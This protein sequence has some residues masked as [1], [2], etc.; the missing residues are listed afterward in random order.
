M[1]TVFP[2]LQDVAMDFAWGGLIDMTKNHLPDFGRLRS[3]IYYAQ[4]FSGHGVSMT[5]L[6]GKLMAEVIAGTAE[7]FDVF[8]RIP[9]RSIPLNPWVRK[10]LL[11]LA[12][13]WYGLQDKLP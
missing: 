5:G 6:A 8:T 1:L 3:N 13:L 7:R 9:H 12:M 4:G 10:S 2:Q 11:S